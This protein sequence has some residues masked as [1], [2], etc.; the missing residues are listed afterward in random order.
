[1]IVARLNVPLSRPTGRRLGE[2]FMGGL[3]LVSETL[4]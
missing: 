4:E 2:G 1:M 3:G